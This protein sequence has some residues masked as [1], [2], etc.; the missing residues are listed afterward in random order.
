MSENDRVRAALA[1]LWISG[2]RTTGDGVS[3]EEN[4]KKAG[5]RDMNHYW[6][7]QLSE[8]MSRSH[9]KHLLATHF[10]EP[11]LVDGRQMYK[12]DLSSS[13][14]FL[15]DTKEAPL[16]KIEGKEPMVR[17]RQVVEC[18]LNMP[19]RAHLVPPSLKA[20]ITGANAKNKPKLPDSEL[21]DF[22]KKEG[23]ARC[24]RSKRRKFLRITFLR[25]WRRVPTLTSVSLRHLIQRRERGKRKRR[26]ILPDGSARVILPSKL[27]LTGGWP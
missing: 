26:S 24:A 19:K 2:S 4:A 25:P 1:T 23:L 13:I 3:D 10:F 7:I 14:E 5:L 22:V 21:L 20:F 9:F 17:T 12:L 16:I 27:S 6:E 18:L 11:T 8:A 15:S